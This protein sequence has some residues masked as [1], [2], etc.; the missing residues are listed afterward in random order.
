MEIANGWKQQKN[1]FKN[2]SLY[3]APGQQPQIPHDHGLRQADPSFSPLL[4]FHF[5]V[6]TKDRKYLPIAIGMRKKCIKYGRR[7]M[8]PLVFAVGEATASNANLNTNCCEPMIGTPTAMKY[9][10]L[11]F[12]SGNPFFCFRQLIHHKAFC[13]AGNEVAKNVSEGFYGFLFSHDGDLFPLREVNKTKQGVFDP[14]FYC[15]IAEGRIDY[16]EVIYFS[17]FLVYL[18]Y[19]WIDDLIIIFAGDH[20]IC[21]KR[22]NERGQALNNFNHKK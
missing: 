18:F 6:N 1:Y 9:E 14:C 4:V 21:F 20:I 2:L 15:I 12:R 7:A 3:R 11:L 13:L 10:P 5:K 19:Y 17:M 22:S 8:I 16:K